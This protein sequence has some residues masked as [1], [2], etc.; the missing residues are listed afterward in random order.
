MSQRQ[1]STASKVTLHHPPLSTPIRIPVGPSPLH[2]LLT[3]RTAFS[4]SALKRE[5]GDGLKPGKPVWAGRLNSRHNRFSIMKD[6]VH[7][8]RRRPLKPVGY[9]S[10]HFSSRQKSRAMLPNTTTF[11][12][13]YVCP[14]AELYPGKAVM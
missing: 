10:G 5:G 12:E 2:G 1:L 11:I 3:N 4:R 14:Q 13:Y 7:L 8:S 9:A 6:C